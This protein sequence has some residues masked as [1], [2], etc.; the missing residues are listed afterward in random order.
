MVSYVFQLDLLANVLGLGRLGDGR[1]TCFRGKRKSQYDKQF[2][3][4]NIVGALRIRQKYEPN[5]FPSVECH[6]VAAGVPNLLSL[7]PMPFGSDSMML[8]VWLP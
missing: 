5:A 8:T 7:N 6:T 4:V 2:G 1:P 3:P